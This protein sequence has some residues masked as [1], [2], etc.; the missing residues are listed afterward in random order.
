MVSLSA[1]KIHASKGV[2]A[3]YIKKGTKLKSIF[4]GGEQ[5]FGIRAGTE[6]IPGIVGMAE[7]VGVIRQNF[8][9]N[10]HHLSQLKKLCFDGLKN[11]I[12]SLFLIGPDIEYG[13]RHILS[14]S[15]PGIPAEVMQRALSAKGVHVGIGA[16][17][18][19]KKRHVSHVL[20]AIGL[21]PE[22]KRSA[23]RISFSPTNTEEQIRKAIV[24]FGEC[25]NEL[26][27]FGR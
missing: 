19:S 10:K 3:L 16:A 17:C 23:I 20:D 18:S 6:N 21:E 15:V 4:S 12:P 11:I 9:A 13:A 5:E 2:G 1:H 27:R 24:V 8:E 22:K 14:V 7:A 25:F 26:S